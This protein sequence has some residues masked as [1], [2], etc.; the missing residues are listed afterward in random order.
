M[1]SK[2]YRSNTNI[3]LINELAIAKRKLF[4]IARKK[5][6]SSSSP[7]SIGG[8]GSL[9]VASNSGGSNNPDTV[10]TISGNILIKNL[11][12][13]AH[14][15]DTT[16]GIPVG[17]CPNGSRTSFIIIDSDV[18]SLSVVSAVVASLNGS[19][20]YADRSAISVS[21]INYQASPYTG[22]LI[23][24]DRAPSSSD[25]LNYAIFNP[26]SSFT[27]GA[28]LTGTGRGNCASTSHPNTQYYERVDFP[29]FGGTIQSI[30]VQA[31][32]TEP[33]AVF[34]MAIYNSRAAPNASPGTKLWQSGSMPI[35]V[36]WNYVGTDVT[37][38][39]NP[40]VGSQQGAIYLAVSIDSDPPLSTPILYCSTPL[41]TFVTTNGYPG[42]P[43]SGP[44]LIPTPGTV[45]P[46]M[47]VARWFELI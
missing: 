26:G 2:A 39:Q 20:N 28:I 9:G 11:L 14:S 35:K 8:S 34:T 30:A 7:T 47:Q 24:C 17:W 36:G 25:N 18:T 31:A 13:R 43:D 42:F 45:G 37:I 12:A 41:T 5:N 40:D 6:T 4:G 15:N 29:T 23:T 46:N 3:D 32:T 22:F 19:D 27:T 1:A 10:T 38:P 33:G 21:L 44:G 16:D